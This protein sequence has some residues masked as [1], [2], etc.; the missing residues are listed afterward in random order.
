MPEPPGRT[1]AAAGLRLLRPVAV[2]LWAVLLLAFWI[3][4]RDAADGPLAL[5]RHAARAVT[6]SA[7]APLGL[8]GLYLLRPLLLVPITAINLATGFLLGPAAG[9]ALAFVGTLLSASAGYLLGRSLGSSAPVASLTARWRFAEFLRQRSF[10]A[11]C[12]GGLMYLHADLVNF[13]AGMLRVPFPTFLL[14]IALGNSL[15]MSMAVLAGAAF[16]GSGGGLPT[17]NLEYVAMAAALF[18]VSLALA[19]LMRRRTTRASG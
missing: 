19:R 4:F 9:I 6:G 7:W 14:G 5:L 3:S 10:E 1:G 8:L 18:I 13:P 11:V 12:A 2:V 16:D 15:T 17:L